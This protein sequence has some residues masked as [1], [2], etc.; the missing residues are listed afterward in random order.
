MPK[1]LAKRLAGRLR[2]AGAVYAT[3]FG[4]FASGTEHPDSDIDIA[5]SFGKPMTSDLKMAM[6]GLIAEV[7]GRTVDLI[8][9]EK[10]SGEILVQALGGVEILCDSNAVRHRLA[11]R[12]RTED[13]RR[14]AAPAAKLARKDLFA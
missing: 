3:V 5:I 6:I 13:E 2:A 7:A 1:N 10:A 14:S 8:D 4:S 12:Q 9:L 11:M